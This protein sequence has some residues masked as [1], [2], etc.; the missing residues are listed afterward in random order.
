MND[1]LEDVLKSSLDI[2]FCGTAA[3]KK[4]AETQSYYAGP[5][6]KF[7]KVLNDIGLTPKILLPEKYTDLLNYNIGLTDIA[8]RV[9]GNDD[10]INKGDYDIESFIR[11]IKKYQPKI[12]CFNGKA[13]GKTFFNIKSVNYGLQSKGF[14]DSKIFIV[15]STSGSANG[16]WDIDYWHEL[17]KLIK[18]K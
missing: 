10:E 8:K 11:K 14:Q 12:I 18:V 16:C 1:I 17:S 9:Y 4:S 3:S 15:P 13:A 5:G 2:V 6:N 7:W